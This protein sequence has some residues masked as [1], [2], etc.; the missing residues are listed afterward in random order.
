MHS[1]KLPLLN[2]CECRCNVME[3]MTINSV[4]WAN[5]SK[6]SLN[7]SSLS[8]NSAFWYSCS[9]PSPDADCHSIC[10]AH[11]MHC[12]LHRSSS[13][14]WVWAF[15]VNWAF[16]PNHRSVSM[17]FLLVDMQVLSAIVGLFLGEIWLLGWWTKWVC[18]HSQSAPFTFTVFCTALRMMSWKW[19]FWRLCNLQ[20]WELIVWNNLTKCT[21]MIWRMM[22]TNIQSLHV[23]NATT[24]RL[25]PI[26]MTVGQMNEPPLWHL[27]N[28]VSGSQCESSHLNLPFLMSDGFLF[29]FGSFGFNNGMHFVQLEQHNATMQKPSKQLFSSCGQLHQL[30]MVSQTILTVENEVSPC[31]WLVCQ[32]TDG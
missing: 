23:C 13:I 15:W 21:I 32:V 6:H 14:E 12:I 17:F 18:C 11:V 26:Q 9:F 22:S 3:K 25:S 7:P 20:D 30:K 2:S 24:A 10:L 29:L 27:E 16:E 31:Q 28:E 8:G 19:A 1:H 4:A 5:I